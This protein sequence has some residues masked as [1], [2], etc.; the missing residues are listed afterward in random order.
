MTKHHQSLEYFINLFC[1]LKDN[2][3]PPCASVRFPPDSPQSE[4]VTSPFSVPSQ[5]LPPLSS[6]ATVSSVI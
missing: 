3:K 2:M 5:F 6:F 1:L 4:R